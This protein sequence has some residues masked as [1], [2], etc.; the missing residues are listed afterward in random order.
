MF[1]TCVL[2]T[3]DECVLDIQPSSNCGI[4][5]WD[6]FLDYGCCESSFE[7][8]LSALAK[9]A[10]QTG[11][12]FLNSS[13]QLSCRSSLEGSNGR[14]LLS[15]GVGKLA[16]GEGGCSDFSLT[17]VANKLQSWLTGLDQDCQLLESRNS[18]SSC[19][20][21]WQQIG[22]FTANSSVEETEICRFAVLVSMVNRKISDVKWI[23]AVYQCL[24]QNQSQKIQ[25]DH[26]EHKKK[27]S[28]GELT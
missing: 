26:H 18:C 3:N 10:N 8:Y 25:H 14:N 2:A 16:A 4:P 21:R 9:H 23:Q 24:G 15:C 7:E 12:I 13:Q 28:I 17:D 5:N 11:P 1:V 27:M 6:G 19:Y 22:A 20:E